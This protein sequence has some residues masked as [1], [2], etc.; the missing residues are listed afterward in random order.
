LIERFQFLAPDFHSKEP[1]ELALLSIISQSFFQPFSIEDNL[2]VILT[3]LTSGS[4]VGF[5]RAMLFRTADDKLKGEAWLGPRSA[6][7]AK[8]I[9][10]VLSTPGIGYI[11][12]IEHNRWLLTRQADSLSQIVKPLVYSLAQDNLT[13]PATSAARKEMLLVRN[14]RQ[15]PQ[16]D[17]KFLEVIDVEEFLCVPLFA[18]REEVMGLIILDNAYTLRP[19]EPKDVKLASLCGLMAGNYMYATLLHNRMI[20]MERLAALGEMAMFITHQL[21]NPLTAIGGFTDQ[22]LNSPSDEAKKRRNLE[23]IR[24]E[25]RRLEDVVDRLARFLKVDLRKMVPFDLPS[26]L[27]GAIQGSALKMKSEEIEIRVDFEE[28]LPRILGDATY[29]GEAFRNLIV[30]AL[31]ASSR[32]GCVSIQGRREDQNWVVVSVHDNGKGMLPAVREK[33]FSS[34][35]STKDKGLGLGLLYVKR[36]MESCGGRIEVDSEAGRGTTF[37]LHFKSAEEG[38]TDA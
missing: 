10:D 5:N 36:V 22:L 37:Q 3:A 31:E 23:I 28:N 2:L 17:P 25:I 11:E 12:I 21:R 19:I 4:G 9:W 6:E 7:E 18:R 27:Q 13:I 35:F 32:G 1:K 8:S 15:E 24:K 26:V 14:A 38:R 29:V 33:L 16:I 20:E 30:N 34:F